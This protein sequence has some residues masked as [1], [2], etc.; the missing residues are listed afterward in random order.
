M[1]SRTRSFVEEGS[2]MARRD[3]VGRLIDELLVATASI[4]EKQVRHQSRM[5][6]AR[7][8]IRRGRHGN[9]SHHLTNLRQGLGGA[10]LPEL[11]LRERLQWRTS[12]TRLR[13]PIWTRIPGAH[14]RGMTMMAPND[15]RRGERA[16]APRNHTESN[17]PPSYS[18]PPI[19]GVPAGSNSTRKTP[20]QRFP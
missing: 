10:L 13:S 7:L 12:R 9:H 19:P 1:S 14:P 3:R 17:R 4:L 15:S 8:Q 6:V 18:Q 20:L 11:A 2:W 16:G 5:G